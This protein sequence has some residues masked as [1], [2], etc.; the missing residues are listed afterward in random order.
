MG[1]IAIV[2]YRPKPGQAEQ[3]QALLQT[4]V[5]VLRQEGLATARE[6]MRMLAGDGTFVEVFEWVSAEAIQ[7]A[8][9]NPAVQRMWQDFEVCCDYVPIGTLPEAAQMFAEFASV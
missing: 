1:R 9:G 2:G 4:H 3:L 6:P 7:A 5:R 8:H